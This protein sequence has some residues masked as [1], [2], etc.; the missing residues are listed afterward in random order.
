MPELDLN[1]I[2]YNQKEYYNRIAETYDIYYSNK[3]ALEYRHKVYDKILTGMDFKNLNVL[4]AM[5]GGGESTGYFLNKGANVTGVDISEKQCGIYSK[6][7]PD[8]P[9]YCTSI[10]KTNFSNEEF[11]FVVTDSLHHLNPNLHEG[12]KEIHRILK[13]GG[14]FL[15]FEP[16]EGSFFNYLR[17]KWYKL[18]KTYFEDNEQSIDIDKLESQYNE[19]FSFKKNIYGGNIAYLLVQESMLF[20]IPSK[21]IK[22]YAPILLPLDNFIQKFQSKRTACWILSLLQKR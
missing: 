6:R 8:I 4:D 17:K 2:E 22:Y 5:C 3:Y 9:V 7:Y 16:S 19:I 10:T 21:L 15:A 12:I 18:D 20:R 14:Y 13:R 11:D 1:K